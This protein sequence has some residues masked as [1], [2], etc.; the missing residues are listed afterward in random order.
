VLGVSI[1]FLCGLNHQL[2]NLALKDTMEEAAEKAG[3]MHD[4]FVPTVF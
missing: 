4:I 3:A 1:I 2:A